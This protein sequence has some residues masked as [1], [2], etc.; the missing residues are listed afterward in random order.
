MKPRNSGAGCRKPVSYTHLNAYYED[1]SFYII[2]YALSNKIKQIEKNPNVAIA[3]SYT[4]LDV[5]KRQG[6]RCV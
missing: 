5:Y 2:T 3:V 6:L 4:H 1:G